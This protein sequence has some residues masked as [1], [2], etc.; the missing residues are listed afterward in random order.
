MFLA[1][2]CPDEYCCFKCAPEL[3]LVECTV[4]TTQ[5]PSTE[6]Q[7]HPRKLQKQ[8]IRRCQKC[9][10]CKYCQTMYDDARH[11]LCNKNVCVSCGHHEKLQRCDVCCTWLA[12][13]KFPAEQFSRTNRNQTLRCSSCH[14]C[15]ACRRTLHA[16]AF[17]GTS[18]TCLQC[19]THRTCGACGGNKSVNSFDRNLL[20]NAHT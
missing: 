14:A 19:S 8:T 17:E 12:A 15:G 1:S 13:D 3:C 7:G 10:T 11:L 6:F 9:F 5:R 4:C 16:N 20:Y 18:S 2:A